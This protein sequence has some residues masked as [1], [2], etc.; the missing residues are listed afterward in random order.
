[1]SQST[2]NKFFGGKEPP[3]KKTKVS[4]EE[5]QKNRKDY[6]ANERKRTFIASWKDGRPWLQFD[7]VNGTIKCDFCTKYCQSKDNNFIVG[8][9]DL[10]LYQIKRHESTNEHRKS[11]EKYAAMTC[12]PGSSVAEKAMN[13]L[14][15]V[16]SDKL[17]ILF[18]NA[19][20]SCSKI[21]F[22]SYIA[23]AVLEKS[24]KKTTFLGTI[25]KKGQ[26]FTKTI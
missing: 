19:H 22:F 20:A 6:E 1:M 8:C 24:L 10:K 15:K 13:S 3:D 11:A 14:T 25:L 23:L 9:K 4:D 21:T 5:K 2:I 16:Q 17:S 12:K 7:T 26:I 18:R